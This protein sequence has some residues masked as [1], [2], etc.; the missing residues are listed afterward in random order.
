M[1]CI[2]TSLLYASLEIETKQK[3]GK[4]RKTRKSTE[5]YLTSTAIW[6]DLLLQD[7]FD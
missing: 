2:L 1:L 5:K 7:V 4:T 3:V 6:L